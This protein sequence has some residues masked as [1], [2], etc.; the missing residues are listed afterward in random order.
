MKVFINTP[1][2]KNFGGVT[3]HYKG[4]RPF[5][6][7]QVRYNAVGKRSSTS[8]SGKYWLPW[9]LLKFILRILIFRPDIVLLNPSL[10]SNS[11]RRDFLFL[12]AA[13]VMG[14]PVAV[15]I[16][17]F[18]LDY[19]DRVNKKWITTYLNKASLIFVLAERFKSILEEWGVHTPIVRTTTKVDDRLLAGFDV[20][21]RNGK[22]DNILFLARVERAKGIYIT[23]DTYAILKKKYPGLTLTIAGEGDELEAVRKYVKDLCLKNVRFTGAVSG[24]ALI[25]E[26]RRADLYLFASY[27][28]GMPASVLEAMAFGLPVFTRRVGGLPDFFENR[29]MG[30]ITDSLNPED[31]ADAMKPYIEDPKL[32]RQVSIYNAHYARE[33]FMASNVA[34]II[35]KELRNILSI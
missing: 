2:P 10:G 33:H 35:E 9:D 12:R 19:A 14:F 7:E 26:F 24:K 20:E 29:K 3:M 30:Y 32:M 17:G 4:L 22:A 34:L 31:F 27:S 15:F 23:I 28:E 13:S 1:F 5:W 21:Q 18:N 25:E 8:V 11:L 6:T 16:H